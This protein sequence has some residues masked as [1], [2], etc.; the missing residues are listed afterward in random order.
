M[1]TRKRIHCT[2]V[3]PEAE[4]L[5]ELNRAIEENCA[6]HEAE[7]RILSFMTMT[8]QYSLDRKQRQKAERKYK[9]QMNRLFKHTLLCVLIG[10]GVLLC[11][12]ANLVT[13]EFLLGS[14]LICACIIAFTCGKGHEK[15][16]QFGGEK[17]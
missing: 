12:V 13:L 6:I 5:R 17:R 10:L 4:E 1:T 7:R 16:S 15:K 9:A 2:I 11:W 8:R 14:G 3:D